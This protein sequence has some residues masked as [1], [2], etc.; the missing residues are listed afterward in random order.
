MVQLQCVTRLSVGQFGFTPNRTGCEWY[1]IIDA[2]HHYALHEIF[3]A[4]LFNLLNLYWHGAATTAEMQWLDTQCSTKFASLGL[5]SFLCLSAAPL[6]LVP[7]RNAVV[8]ISGLTSIVLQKQ[9]D[10][11]EDVKGKSVRIW[12]R[13]GLFTGHLS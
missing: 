5:F 1:D 11:P 6:S 2:T 3:D 12:Q 7:S 10:D 13:C 8:T 4:Q 9:E